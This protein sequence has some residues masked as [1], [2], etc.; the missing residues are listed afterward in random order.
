MDGQ[1]DRPPVWRAKTCSTAGR[2][3]DFAG[4]GAGGAAWH[5]LALGFLQWI[6]ERRRRLARK[7]PIH[8]GA[9]GAVGS[10]LAS[11]I[12]AVDQLGQQPPVVAS[13]VGDRLAANQAM[14]ASMPRWSL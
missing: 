12:V 11:G 10:H 7:F 2:T 9:I 13:R 1:R 3:A 5:R 8:L 4:I 14:P 6:C